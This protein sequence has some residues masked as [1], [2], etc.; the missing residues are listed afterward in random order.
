MNAA[1]NEQIKDLSN[2]VFLY[3]VKQGCN[4]EDAKDIV[5]QALYKALLY[6]DSIDQDKLSAWVFKVSINQY[7]DV[8]RRMNRTTD[9]QICDMVSNEK[10]LDDLMVENEGQQKV[11]ETLN[12][13]SPVYKQ[14]LLLKY[15]TLLSY[16][17][18]GNV[19]DM[20][21]NKVKTYL[22]R[23]RAQFKELFRRDET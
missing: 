20:N 11:R 17:E 6:M 22:A 10:M 18:I 3:L 15:D 23:A 1:F 13:L 4:R 9:L 5:Q 16:K 2:K 19:L 8:C 14:I 21:E 7:Y 12:L